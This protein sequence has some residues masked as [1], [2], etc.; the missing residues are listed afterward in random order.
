MLWVKERDGETRLHCMCGRNH[1]TEAELVDGVATKTTFS[2]T[3]N[4]ITRVSC[5]CGMRSRLSGQSC[6]DPRSCLACG[7]CVDCEQC[8]C[9]DH[10]A[11]EVYR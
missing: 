4:G 9:R 11:F 2:E 7:H 5:A 1:G 6:D 10:N 3:I 8:A